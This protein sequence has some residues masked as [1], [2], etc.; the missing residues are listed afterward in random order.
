MGRR[1]FPLVVVII[2][3]V[4]AP[5]LRGYLKFG[6]QVGDRMVGLQWTR[7]PIRYA[8][9]SR[10][11]TG[12]SA[13]QLQTAV[14]H[15][16]AEWDRPANVAI[17]SQFQGFTTAEPFNDDA[18]SVIGFRSRPELDR[19]LGATTFVID[20]TT[21]EILE[22]D[23][24]LNSAFTWSVAANGE[25]NKFDVESVVVHE[26]GHFLGLGHSALGETELRSGGG[27]TVLG[28]R[29]VMFPIAYPA[30]SIA[31]RTLQAD[32]VSGITD[33]Y[34]D[35]TAQRDLG[36]I[37]GRVTLNGA[38]VFG[39]HVTA[40]NPATGEL[41]SGFTLTDQGEFVIG[42]LTPG[43]YIVRVEP[44]DDADVDGFFE[45]DTPVNINFQVAYY[46]RQVAVPAGGA[47]PAIAIKVKSK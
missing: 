41:V 40:F 11:V 26:M 14:A 31:D 9:T 43:R 45:S 1:L 7:Q 12:V 38:G 32:D 42:A 29:A 5:G 27:R 23:I 22:A 18:T 39:A 4:L 44:L 24:F 34:G 30:G 13:A 6:V 20:D 47:G 33:I 37:Q 15:A 21:G 10:D 17:A 46:S 3:F 25:A 35:A 36:A 28:K 16:F 19:T 8:V 2:A